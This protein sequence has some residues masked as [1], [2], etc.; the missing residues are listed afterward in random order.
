MADAELAQDQALYVIYAQLEDSSAEVEQT[1][2]PFG[3]A[4]PEGS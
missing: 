2:Q 4:M 1:T 3:I